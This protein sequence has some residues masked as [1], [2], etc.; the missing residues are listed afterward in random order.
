V[1]RYRCICVIDFDWVHV[2]FI[3]WSVLVTPEAERRRTFPPD[4]W[5]S[6]KYYAN[7]EKQALS[8]DI[9]GMVTPEGMAWEIL[10]NQLIKMGHYPPKTK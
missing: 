1:D 5:E 9:R 8:E 7:D 4:I 3:L 6:L 2:V 10:K